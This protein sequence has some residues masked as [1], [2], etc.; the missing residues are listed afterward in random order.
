MDIKYRKRLAKN[1]RAYRNK[2]A[3]SQESLAERAD[4]H[5][6]FISGVERAKYNLSLSSL[7]RIAK[8]LGREPYEL[9]K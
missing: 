5:W 1:V 4:M 7:V 9:L 6:T 2:M 3:L 8:A